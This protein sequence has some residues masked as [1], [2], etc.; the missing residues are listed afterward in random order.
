MKRI[1]LN[2]NIYCLTRE[3][4]E[5]DLKFHIAQ[6]KEHLAA[7]E[8]DLFEFKIVKNGGGHIHE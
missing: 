1:K 4:T 3:A 8:A 2:N 6:A 7:L 5:E